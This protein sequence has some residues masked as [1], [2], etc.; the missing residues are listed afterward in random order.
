MFHACKR[1]DHHSEEKMEIK[2]EDQTISLLSSKRN[3][4]TTKASLKLSW[5][6]A[7]WQKNT[8]DCGR[9]FLGGRWVGTSRGQPSGKQTSKM[10]IIKSKKVIN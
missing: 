10:Y 7:M 2:E 6:L 4:T 3:T 1:W 5:V 9:F 8:L